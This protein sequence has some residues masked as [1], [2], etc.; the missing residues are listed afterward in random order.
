[1][2]HTRKR[3][4]TRLS[5]RGAPYSVWE[6]PVAKVDSEYL[7]CVVYIY[8]SE[9]DAHAGEGFGGSGFLVAKPFRENPGH[10][11]VYAVTNNHVINKCPQTVAVRLNT[12]DGRSDVIVTNPNDWIR[13]PDAADIRVIPIKPSGV[14]RYSMIPAAMFLSKDMVRDFNIGL[15][16]DTFVVGRFVNHEGK[17]R[18]TPSL[19]FGNI[20]MMPP[21]P[22]K[23]QY[24]I[25]QESFLVECRSIPGYSEIG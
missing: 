16:H 21:E 23:D 25:D 22:I 24:G 17:Q 1:M 6:S 11:A 2:L 20:A 12:I 14:H 19:R 9:R 5:S 15:V 10:F 18:N 4:V 8:K 7:N 3:R 13:H